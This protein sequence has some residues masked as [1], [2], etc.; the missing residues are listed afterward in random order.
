MHKN[1]LAMSTEPSQRRFQRLYEEHYARLFAYALRRWP[2]AS[3]AQDVV[4]DTFLVLWRRLDD[5]PMDDQELT[6]WLYGVIRRVLAN[7][8]RARQRQERLAERF[9]EIVRELPETEELAANRLEAYRLLEALLELTEQEREIL[10]LAG[11]ERLSTA[12][13]GAVLG[14]SENAAAIRLHRARKRLTEVY[15]KENERAGH[16]RDQRLR[17]RQPPHDRRRNDE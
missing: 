17:L 4:A 8:L 10:L 2:D 9:S 1:V 3:G 6:L 16:K 7:R 13:L 5:A 12:Q 15:K 11:W 14:C